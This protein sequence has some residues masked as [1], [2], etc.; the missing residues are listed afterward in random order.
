M[1][2]SEVFLSP[3]RSALLLSSF[4]LNLPLSDLFFIS[5]ILISFSCI[6]QFLPIPKAWVWR[7][8]VFVLSFS[9]FT[10]SLPLL[11]LPWNSV[12]L[13]LFPRVLCLL[14]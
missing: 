5:F 9:P 14:W 6:I 2:H 10:L 4:W 3:N 7:E 11:H 12:F 1:F 13:G 8:K